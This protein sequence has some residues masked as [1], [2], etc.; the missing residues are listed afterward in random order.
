MITMLTAYKK[1]SIKYN[2][3]DYNKNSININQYIIMNIN[4]I[5]NNNN[6]NSR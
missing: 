4:V 6:N 1:G 3:N 5:V 2:N